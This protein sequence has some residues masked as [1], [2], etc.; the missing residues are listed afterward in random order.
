MRT[1]IGVLLLSV[2]SL[3]S[4]KDIPKKASP[5]SAT[6]QAA[7]SAYN[8]KNYSKAINLLTKHLRSNQ[9]DFH[10]WNL[11]ASAYFHS[12]QPDKALAFFRKVHKRTRRKDFNLLYQGL[13]LEMMNEPDQAR[14]IYQSLSR[15]H[16]KVA[17]KAMFQLAVMNYHT[18]NFSKAQS[19]AKQY[20]K[21]FPRGIF[22]TKAQKLI[23][24]INQDEYLENFRG[25]PMPDKDTALRRYHPLSLS[26][27]IPN[28]W[29]FQAGYTKTSEQ[30][31]KPSYSSA[32][33]VDVVVESHALNASFG[34]G[35]GPLK[36]RNAEGYLGYMYRQRWFADQARYA[37]WLDDIASLDYFMF[38]A[39]LLE[40]T[41]S[42]F[43]YFKKGFGDQVNIGL[44]ANA[45]FALIGT[46]LFPSPEGE[47]IDRVLP[48]GNTT[49]V[50]PWFGVSWTRN[51]Q[52]IFHILLKT[53][54]NK[55]DTTLSS[56]SYN[57][58]SGKASGSFGLAQI[59]KFP[60]YRS[61]VKLDVISYTHTFNDFWLDHT[62]N[63]IGIVA[64]HDINET[65][66]LKLRLGTF[67]DN[68][69]LDTIRYGSCSEQINNKNS[70]GQEGFILCNRS[71]NG[72]YFELGGSWNLSRHNSLTMAYNYQDR[73]NPNLPVYDGN[74]S[75][76]ILYW[77]SAFPGVRDVNKFSIDFDKTDIA[78]KVSE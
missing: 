59:A 75:N 17:E 63:G 62:R 40:R 23:A 53:Q 15:G 12:G 68:Y 73:H 32:E 7:I 77:T 20:L 4:S 36:Q 48:L 10:A 27:T 18:F 70:S 58:E 37:T 57:F 8:R 69:L 11:M 51:H 43:T 50:I 47:Q 29:Y 25:V 56:R 72:R 74:Q 38:R 28:F 24:A 71:D 14:K 54:I 49:N 39:D 16:T 55:E 30:N 64:E 44:R 31:V 19:R 13:S 35:V 46:S 67:T 26:A 2:A 22:K 3:A 41:H 60:E 52:T 9:R 45:D 42:L 61:R 66:A 78:A 5:G 65:L 6:K 34:V 21:R 76:F 1:K 33:L